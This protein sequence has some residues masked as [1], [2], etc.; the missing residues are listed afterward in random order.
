M[1]RI[2]AAFFLPGTGLN[3]NPLNC[4]QNRS[5]GPLTERKNSAGVR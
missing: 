1:Q 4:T 3:K 5:N 2:I